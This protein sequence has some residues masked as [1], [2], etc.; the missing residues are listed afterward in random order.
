M[1]LATLARPYAAAVFELAAETD[2]LLQWV[3]VLSFLDVVVAEPEMAKLVKNPSFDKAAL[4]TILSELC[5]EQSELSFDEQV[6][7]FIKLLVGNGRLAVLP[8][9]VKQFEKLKAIHEN[10]IRVEVVSAY[11]LESL[12]KKELTDA[13]E[14]RF[15]KKVELEVTINQALMGGW[16]IR[17]GDEVVD[18]SVLG[19]YQQL[20]THLH[21]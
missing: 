15:G 8:E 2:A 16:L 18:L 6:E 13:L 4:R 10:Y 19:R 20:A 21:G 7:N 5:K 14:Q 17:V 1:E 11:P 9:M 3:N 12:Q